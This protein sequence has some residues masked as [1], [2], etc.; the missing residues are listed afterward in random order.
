MPFRSLFKRSRADPEA[1][2]A[3]SPAPVVLLKRLDAV[4]T[5]VTE[6]GYRVTSPDPVAMPALPCIV[7]AVNIS[8]AAAEHL[9]S[10]SFHPGS[11]VN[12][13]YEPANPF[14]PHAIAV[15]DR[16]EHAIGYLS[17]S[18]S[19]AVHELITTDQLGTAIVLANV[20][21]NASIHLRLLIVGRGVGITFPNSSS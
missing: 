14:D 11:P 15:L 9:A 17:A 13:A 2:A 7:A 6:S 18:D 3:V 1:A 19:A 21:T 12:L 8:R 5:S 4:A 10:A 20:E 16:G